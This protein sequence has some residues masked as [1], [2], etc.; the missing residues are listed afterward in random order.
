MKKKNNNAAV[1]VLGDALKS[2]EQM[3]DKL[4]QTAI[5]SPPYY[6]LRD[7]GVDGQIGLEQSPQEYIAKL[8]SVFRE[9]KRV[10][11]DDGTLWIN[12]GD[13][14]AGSGGYSPDSPANQ[15]GSKQATNKGGYRRA[16]KTHGLPAKNL[17]GMPWRLALALQDD[18]WIL[19]QEV[20]WHKPNV[21]P[22]SVRDRLVVDH[23]QIFLFAK[24]PRYFFDVEAV[25]EPAVTGKRL[26]RTLWSIPSQPY[27]GAHTAVFPPKLV[28]PMILASTPEAGVCPIC[29]APKRRILERKFYGDCQPQARTEDLKLG[30]YKMQ[31]PQKGYVP[32]KTIG[33][34]P[35]C[36]CGQQATVPAIVLDPFMGSGTVGQVAASLGRRFIGIE[37][38]E[39]YWA[40]AWQRTTKGFL[41]TLIR[42]ENKT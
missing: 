27:K 29:R 6:Q 33:W 15:Q 19:R 32:P 4:V 39:E 8:V 35:T 30:R 36:S 7:Y 11:R 22:Q 37:L 16:R 18:G 23:E 12:M 9:V 26:K 1:L 28:E 34:E 42:H 21:M 17:M 20:I 2:L 31:F 10:L 3:P 38:N 14:Y 25:K 24:Q 5:T 13:T 40:L 41:D